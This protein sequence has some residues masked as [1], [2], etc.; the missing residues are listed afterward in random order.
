MLSTRLLRGSGI[1]RRGSQ[2]LA[3]TSSRRGLQLAPHVDGKDVVSPGGRVDF[4]RDCSASERELLAA[5]FESVHSYLPA[6]AT[7][8]HWVNMFLN[9]QVATDSPHNAALHEF[10]TKLVDTAYA[11]WNE[12]HILSVSFIVNPAGSS[13]DQHFHCDY[14][15]TS[16]D[17][18]IAMSPVTPLNAMQYIRTPLQKSRMEHSETSTSTRFSGGALEDIIAEEGTPLEL[19]QVVSNPWSIVQM[20]PFTPHRGIGNREDYDRVMF[21]VCVDQFYHQIEEEAVFKEFEDYDN[22]SAESLHMNGCDVQSTRGVN[23]EA[24]GHRQSSMAAMEPLG[25]ALRVEEEA[26]AGLARMGSR[27]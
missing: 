4:V 2:R 7:E 6:G 21:C 27:V 8:I 24:I 17:L 10:V 22:E 1:L 5:A 19:G 26:P 25:R 23:N 14:T 3:F 16:S 18:F 15:Y 12:R 9:G 20:Q 13:V 11:D